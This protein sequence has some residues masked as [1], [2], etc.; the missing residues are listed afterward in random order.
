[1]RYIH[2][3]EVISA[4]FALMIVTRQ[5]FTGDTKQKIKCMTLYLHFYIYV[6]TTLFTLGNIHQSK[7]VYLVSYLKT[8]Y[9]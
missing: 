5:G 6:I 4:A 1:M 3:Q 2:L 8:T 7:F 9:V